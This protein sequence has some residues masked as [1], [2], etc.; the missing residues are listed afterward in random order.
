MPAFESPIPPGTSP[1]ECDTIPY[2]PAIALDPK[3]ATTD[4]P[5]GATTTVT[6]PFLTGDGEAQET[7]H[8]K[9]ARLALPIG[10]SLNPSA[11]NG[12]QACSDAQ[13]G[14]GTKQPVG[15]PPASKIGTVTIESPPLPEGV[16]EGDVFVGEQLSR[17]PASGDEYRI[18]VDAES[19]AT[20]S[21]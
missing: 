13:F 7:S 17:D 21:R 10:V 4:S 18:F 16:L 6:V 2:D 12:L 20:A 19:A 3:T 5:S 14:K 9:E 11:A 8:T 1:K 15:C